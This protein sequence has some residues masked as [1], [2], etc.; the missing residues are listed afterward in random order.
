MYLNYG[1]LVS[2]P[3]RSKLGDL[4]GSK[5][6]GPEGPGPDKTRPKPD[7]IRPGP[8][9]TR[10]PGCPGI[11][12]SL[13]HPRQLVVFYQ[14]S[15][16][17]SSNTYPLNTNTRFVDR[18]SCG[19]LTQL[20]HLWICPRSKENKALD[21]ELSSLDP[22]GKCYFV[23]DEYHHGFF[24]YDSVKNLERPRPQLMN[25]PRLLTRS[26]GPILSDGQCVNFPKARKSCL[27]TLQSPSDLFPCFSL[28]RMVS[29]MTSR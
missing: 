7:P 15:S 14:S 26:V 16:Y 20:L 19:T 29:R 23:P 9:P 5:I 18:D 2:L 4:Y 3:S 6:L 8:N 28:T 22:A 11:T 10:G 17:V 21:D 13:A 25:H 1:Y 12:R 24:G 27:L